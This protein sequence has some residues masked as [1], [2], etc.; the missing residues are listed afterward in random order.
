MGLRTPPNKG[1]AFF[2]DEAYM[3]GRDLIYGQDGGLAEAN[4]IIFRA[5]MAAGCL[6][7]VMAGLVYAAAFEMF[8]SVAALV[9]LTMVVFEPNLIAHGA[10]VT[11]DMGVTCFLFGTVYALYRFREHGTWRRLMM[12]GVATGLAVGCEAFRRAASADCCFSGMLRGGGCGTGEAGSGCARVWGGVRRGD[13]DWGDDSLGDV[14]V[15]FFGGSGWG[16]HG[17]RASRITSRRCTGWSRRSIFCWARLHVLPE[18]YLYGLGDI[19]MLSV[20]ATSF[21]TYLLGQIHAH[22]VWYYFPVAFVVK[23]TAGFMLL[24]LLAMYAV[25]VGTAAGE[26]GSRFWRF[27]RRFIC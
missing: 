18:S 12:L 21:P 3:D 23:S 15:S 4:R 22:G 14:W 11:T 25:G 26:A 6:S 1:L 10:Y 13:G 8:G 2:K 5:R 7:L 9:A 16:V 20:A 17:R 19:R 27:P 24:V